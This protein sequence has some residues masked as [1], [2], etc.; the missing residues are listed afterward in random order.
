MSNNVGVVD[1]FELFQNSLNTL[2]PAAVKY[3][4]TLIVF[5]ASL[6]F[7]YVGAWFLRFR[8]S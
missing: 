7:S 8:L 2:L 3:T 6:A 5:A 1:H 4:M